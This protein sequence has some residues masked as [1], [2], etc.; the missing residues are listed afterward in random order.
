M[1]G[2]IMMSLPLGVA[3]GLSAVALTHAEVDGLAGP[4]DDD[5]PARHIKDI[6]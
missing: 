5:A 4:A 6:P 2:L 1:L 3:V